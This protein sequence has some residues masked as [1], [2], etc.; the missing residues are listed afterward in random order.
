MKWIALIAALAMFPGCFGKGGPVEND[1][2][3][4]ATTAPDVGT[5]SATTAPDG[6]ALV[7]DEERKDPVVV[8]EKG[9]LEDALGK[10]TVFVGKAVNAK[11]A[12]AV[13]TEQGVIY[14]LDLEAW[15]DAVVGEEVTVKGTLQR[16]DKFKAEVAEDG[17]ISQGS[18][19][20]D[21]VLH[22]CSHDAG[23]E[24]AEEEEAEEKPAAE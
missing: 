21:L 17:A 12:A 4:P 22:E 16:T 20:G 23:G 1:K 10:T 13:E 24:E 15:P 7:E 6:E 14:C 11:I 19:G 2:P 8:S 5:E 9:G 3:E 18:A